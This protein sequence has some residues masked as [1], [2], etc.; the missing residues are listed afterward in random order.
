[1]GGHRG[2][3]KEPM[4]WSDQ[5]EHA[6]IGILYENVKSGRLQCSTFT[7]DEWAKINQA[8]IAITKMDYGIDRL[9]GKWNCYVRCIACSLNF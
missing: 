7:K 2:K 3:T 6:F 4:S 5:N 9:K 8:M 1:M